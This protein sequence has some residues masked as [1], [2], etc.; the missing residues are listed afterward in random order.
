MGFIVEL[1]NEPKGGGTCKIYVYYFKPKTPTAKGVKMPKVAVQYNGFDC[2]VTRADFNPETKRVRRSNKD[3]AIINHCIEQ[4]IK[5]YKEQ[6]SPERQ[7]IDQGYKLLLKSAAFKTPESAANITTAYNKFIKVIGNITIAELTEAT[8]VRFLNGCTGV[9][10]GTKAQYGKFITRMCKQ[11]KPDFNAFDNLYKTLKHKRKKRAYAT[12]EEIIKIENH[13]GLLTRKCYRDVWLFSYY[14]RGMRFK[15]IVSLTGPA[16]T[17]SKNKKQIVLEFSAKTLAII[18]R[19]QG[20][21]PNGHIFPLL[22]GRPNTR[23]VRISIAYSI[24]ATMVRI[25]KKEGIDKILGIHSARHSFANAAKKQGLSLKMMQGLLEHENPNT[26]NMYLADFDDEE[27][28]E[29]TRALNL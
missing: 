3:Y 24:R 27:K 20:Q 25:C 19:W 12:R 23:E 11:V 26:T 16:Y 22:A 1:G 10:N 18:E 13:A 9:N 7:T 4:T 2:R 6:G 29:A 5:D 14:N 21:D 15:D 17:T 28:K 8:A